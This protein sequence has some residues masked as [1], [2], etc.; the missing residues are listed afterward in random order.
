MFASMHPQDVISTP[1]EEL[2]F[3][4]QHLFTHANELPPAE[5]PQ[6]LQDASKV[7]P[8]GRVNAAQV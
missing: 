6:L 5:L 8:W 1:L 4:W 3:V 7:S 2:G